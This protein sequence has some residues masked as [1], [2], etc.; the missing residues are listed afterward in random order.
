MFSGRLH[1]AKMSLVVKRSA[2]IFNIWFSELQS[3]LYSLYSAYLHGRSTLKNI[4]THNI[5]KNQVYKKAYMLKTY[6]HV[7]SSGARHRNQYGEATLSKHDPLQSPKSPQNPRKKP[8]Y[9]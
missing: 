5:H 9:H 8:P 4:Y 2:Y 1:N 7:P 3:S 6:I